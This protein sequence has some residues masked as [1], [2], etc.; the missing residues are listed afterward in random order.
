MEIKP[1]KKVVS[2]FVG[3][4]T[5]I[6]IL[7]LLVL[8]VVS[9]ERKNVYYILLPMIA[10]AVYYI[11]FSFGFSWYKHAEVTDK[12][13]YISYSVQDVVDVMGKDITEYR[14]KG[15]DKLVVKGHDLVVYGNITVKEP[16]M[17]VKNVK[18]CRIFDY[19]EEIKDLLESKK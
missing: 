12:G 13:K 5:V 2:A 15:V 7:N 19:T 16:M 10:F 14:I 11:I 4:V 6:F 18:K 8:F 9:L 1:R 3:Y 17:K